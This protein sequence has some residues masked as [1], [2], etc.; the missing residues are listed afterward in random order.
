MATLLGADLDGDGTP[1][2]VIGTG[3]DPAVYV[4]AA[5]G[6][7]ALAD[8]DAV[9]VADNRT[10][11]EPGGGVARLADRDGDGADELLIGAPLEDGSGVAWILQGRYSVP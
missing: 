3:A 9:G 7:G 10:A 6:T 8:A 4:F 11:G 5:S 2:L 1:E